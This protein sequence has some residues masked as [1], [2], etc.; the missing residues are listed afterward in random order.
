MFVLSQKVAKMALWLRSSP[1]SKLIALYHRL[2]PGKKDL[3][4]EAEKQS[5]LYA[6]QI[7]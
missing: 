4:T 7:L 3:Q 5:E 1:L 6:D 2:W